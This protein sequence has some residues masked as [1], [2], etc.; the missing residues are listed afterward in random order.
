MELD[1]LKEKWKTATVQSSVDIKD[2]LTKKV[3]S[4]KQSGRSIRR[5]FYIEMAFVA[6]AYLGFIWLVLAMGD[7]M[8][9]YMYKLVAA[10]GI[11]TVPVSWRMYKSQR[12][13]N[14]MDYT[15]DMR[16]NMVAFLSY[17]KTTLRWYQWSTYIIILVILVLFFTDGD[18][19]AL[20]YKVKVTAVVYLV[21]VFLL[22]EPYIRMVY[23]KRIAVFENFL[24]E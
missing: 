24:K 19:I 18:F 1:D 9:S 22:T 11:A 7:S 8:F 20:P 4:I 15:I 21:A 16:S 12:W 3:S 23:G 17:Y 14:S 13:I 6:V 10:T 2:V 5:V